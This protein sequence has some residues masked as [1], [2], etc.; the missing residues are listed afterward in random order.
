[1]EETKLPQTENKTPTSQT[2]AAGLPWAGVAN[3]KRKHS[4]RRPGEAVAMVADA[5]DDG[6]EIMV[7]SEET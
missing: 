2:P 3:R 6:V 1:M 7:A 4:R 5:V